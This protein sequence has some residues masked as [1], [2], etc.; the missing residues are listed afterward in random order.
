M[1]DSQDHHTDHNAESSQDHVQ[2]IIG[3]GKFSARKSYY[4]E[5][6]KKIEELH[7][8]KNK[9]ERIFAEA[10]GGIFQARPG[11]RILVANPAMI[12]LCG[13]PSLREFESLID[14][15]QQLF[16]SET[17]YRKLEDELQSAGAVISFE[18]QFR[19][20]DGSLVDV[21]L[22]AS[23]RTAEQGQYLECF[24]ENITERKQAEEK[25]LRLKKLES[26][27]VLAGGIAHDFNNLLTGLLGNIEMAKMYVPAEN[28]SQALLDTAIR[29]LERGA[30]LTE[31][32][33]TFAKGGEPIKVSLPLEPVLRE[34]AEFILQGEQA[35]LQ[36]DVAP[37]LWPVA[38]DK[39][40]LGQVV[41]NL[42]LNAQQAM[43]GGGTILIR[44]ENI[45]QAGEAFVRF[46]VSDEGTGIDSATLEKIFDPYFT[47]KP[48]GNGLGLAS[49]YSIVKKHQGT[50][51][52]TSKPGRGT[53][54]V[55]TLPAA[56]R[57]VTA[58]VAQEKTTK[59][60][61]GEAPAVLVLESQELIRSMTAH[62]LEEM[63]YRVDLA[64]AAEEA[65]QHCRCAHGQGWFFAA[66]LLDLNAP[67][68]QQGSELAYE[69]GRICPQ[70]RIIASSSYANDP[71]LI[72]LES[73]GFCGGIVKPFRYAELGKAF[74][75]ALSSDLKS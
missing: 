1:T 55:V 57:A 21:L 20:Y 28:R 59:R 51:S 44:A 33:M 68:A 5:L 62:M 3:L 40:Q 7:Q 36:F 41:T 30:G 42:V 50:I 13:Y 23:L 34:N 54:F 8:E 60:L 37:D 12:Q 64:G 63:G 17:D 69:I 73:S 39:G 16:A 6:Q 27:G 52:V 38:A 4:P 58:V 72:D 67:G 24:V 47:T 46:A 53:T 71:V 15:S 10:L 29:A 45:E 65:L 70:T 18:T 2:S 74:E 14:I 49:T 43:P 56:E 26:L 75:D 11:G 22:N 35:T 66:V 31:R 25:Q 9:F 48:H 19:C 61:H 32:L